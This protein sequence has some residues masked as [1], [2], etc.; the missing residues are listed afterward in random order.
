MSIDKII[1][2]IILLFLVLGAIDKI[3]GNKFGLGNKFDEGILAMGSIA[4]S[5]I[6]I[7]SLSNVIASLLGP[8]IIPIYK[9]LGADPSMFATTILP[10]D[11]GGTN[12]AFEFANDVKA[13]E[14]ASFIVGS[15]MGPTIA[16]SIPVAI[17]IISKEDHRYFALGIASG[18]VTIPIGAFIGGKIAGYNTIF[19]LKNLIPITIVSIILS[20][21]LIFIREILI[22]VFNIFSKF[23][24]IIST[25]GLVI[26]ILETLLGIKIINFVMNGKQITTLPI[27]DGIAIVSSIAIVL[28]GSFP[29]VFVI[30][31]IAS[32]PLEFLGSKLG[33][34]NVGSAG[35]IATLAN[36]I[37][38]F[39]I[40]KNMNIQSKIINSAFAVSSAFTFGDHM[41]FTIGYASGKYRE[42]ILPMIIAKLVG[43][44]TAIVIAY[45][46][47]KIEIKNNK[48]Y[49]IES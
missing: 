44:I 3:I 5:V 49:T 13:G 18:M 2:Y 8:I 1:L 45:F 10:L 15:M 34:N 41:A 31:K 47:S 30:T 39:N 29:L 26:S 21:G 17:G 28:A 22:K 35:L 4:L 16:F 42:M 43:G 37:P 24:V 7:V 6:G 14:F 38:M 25:S 20:I 27:N 9:F 19:I 23:L 36:N 33:M 32:K 12:L 40:M 48:I 11:M 46:V